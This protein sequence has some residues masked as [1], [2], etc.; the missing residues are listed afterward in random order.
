MKFVPAFA[1][2]IPNPSGH[3]NSKQI[4]AG[5]YSSLVRRKRLKISSIAADGLTDDDNDDDEGKDGDGDDEKGGQTIL[6][7]IRRIIRI[8]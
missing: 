2:F 6:R 8:I 4:D 5:N 1:L 7:I 3:C